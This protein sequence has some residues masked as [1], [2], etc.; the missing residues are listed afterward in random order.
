MLLARVKKCLSNPVIS[1]IDVLLATIDV[2]HLV[3][4]YS[5]I[6][7]LVSRSDKG[8]LVNNINVT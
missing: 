3:W 4:L 2:L 7:Y 6:S 1:V 8:L 5:N